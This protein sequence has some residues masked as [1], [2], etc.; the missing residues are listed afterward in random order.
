VQ[1]LF[2]EDDEHRPLPEPLHRL[3][4]QRWVDGVACDLCDDVLIEEVP[5][6]LEFNGISYA[7]MLVT[8]TDLEEFARGFALTEG[9]VQTVQQIYGVDTKP[10][11]QGIVLQVEIANAC[12][13]GLKARRRALAGR[14]GCGLCGVESLDQVARP[15]PRP[16][17][18]VSGQVVSQSAVFKALN[19]MGKM[20][21][22]FHASGASHAAA[23][24]DLQGNILAVREDVGRHNALDKLVGATAHLHQ[25]AMVLVSS[26]ASFEMVQKTLAA[27]HVALAAVS[28]PTG[29]A[30][31]MAKEHGLILVGFVRGN[32]LTVYAGAQQVVQ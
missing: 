23:L 18:D 32:R 17:T 2:P 21:P 13:H 30:Q 20:Q 3:T 24:A 28:A 5:V 12:M 10:T 7:T 16:A 31:R 8:P 22:L 4:V 9:I 25:Q 29:M 6:A 1:N 15:L 27:G 14:T 19:A 26:R 11:S